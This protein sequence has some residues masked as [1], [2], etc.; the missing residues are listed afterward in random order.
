MQW[1]ELVNKIH[2]YLYTYFSSTRLNRK[3]FVRFLW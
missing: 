3:L 2:A 1:M